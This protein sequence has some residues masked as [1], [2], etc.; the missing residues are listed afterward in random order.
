[1]AARDQDFLEFVLDQL[2]GL[3]SLSSRRMFGGIGIY[4]AATFFAV[5]DEGRLYFV[6]DDASRSYYEAAGM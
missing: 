1:M 6:T 2:A 3:P 4:Q 5:I